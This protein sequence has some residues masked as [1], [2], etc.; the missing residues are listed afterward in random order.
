MLGRVS[1][2]SASP[3]QGQSSINTGLISTSVLNRLAERQILPPPVWF[4]DRSCFCSL[5]KASVFLQT[6]F[7]SSTSSSW[8]SCSSSSSTNPLPSC[9]VGSTFCRVS[10]A[11]RMKSLLPVTSLCSC[12][13]ESSPSCSR[14]QKNLLCHCFSAIP[15]WGSPAAGWC[16]PLYSHCRPCS[17]YGQLILTRYGRVINQL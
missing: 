11:S 1:F 5:L 6:C 10:C 2:L 16:L 14:Y 8:T 4:Q 9:G 3:L 7:T 12:L 15:S 17:L 13:P